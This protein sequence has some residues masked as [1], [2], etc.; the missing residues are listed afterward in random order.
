MS[1]KFVLLVP[2][3]LPDT[4]HKLL[5]ILPTSVAR[6]GKSAKNGYCQLKYRFIVLDEEAFTQL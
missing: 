5:L 1:Q 2:H 4:A 3:S 6:S